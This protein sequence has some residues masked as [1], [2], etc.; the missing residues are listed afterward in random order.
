[1]KKTFLK[2]GILSIFIITGVAF[3]NSVAACPINQSTNIVA[4]TQTGL[5]GVGDLSSQWIVAFLDWFKS[6]DASLDYVELDATDVKDDCDLSSFSNLKLYIQPGGDAYKQQKI[7]RQGGKDNILD[8][9]NNNGAY[10]GICAGFYYAATDYYW[11]GS[12]Y[13]WSYVL[14]EFPTVEG[15]IVEIADYDENPGYAVTGIDDEVDGEHFQ[16][17]YYGGPTRGYVDTSE[18]HPGNRV[19]TFS[20]P[21]NGKNL[22]A[23]VRDGKKLMLTVHP[24]AYEGIGIEGLTTEQRI[25][26]YKWLANRIND[27]AGTNFYVPPY[28]TPAPQCSDGVDN[29]GDNYI[30]YPNDPGCDSADDNNETDPGSGC[31]D[32]FESG[33]LSDWTLSGPGDPWQAETNTVHSGSYAAEARGTGAGDDAFMEKDITGCGTTFSYYRKLVGLDGVDDFEAGYY[34]NETWTT[35]EQLGSYTANDSSFVYKSFTIPSTASKIRF[36]CECGAVSEACIVDDIDI[37]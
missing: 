36:K 3:S 27:V 33:S 2:M 14:G 17:T 26:N 19:L 16:M 32:G 20:T 31:F 24:E 29:D 4:Y 7:L 28:E 6:Q 9:L 23:G 37:N 18:S 30:D 13:D 1:M 10:L 25:E 34:D 15:S 11:Q 12:Y 21:V 35:V 8:F 5:G 22:L